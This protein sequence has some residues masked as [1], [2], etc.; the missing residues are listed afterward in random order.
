V[1]SKQ[2]AKPVETVGDRLTREQIENL[3]I[4]PDGV[5]EY[6]PPKYPGFVPK[7][8]IFRYEVPLDPAEGAEPFTFDAVGN[9]TIAECDELQTMLRDGASYEAFWDRLAWRITAWNALAYDLASG[10][11]QPVP[12]PVEG[13]HDSFR[14]IEPALTA[15]MA[16]TIVNKVLG[17]GDQTRPKASGPTPAPAS[18]GD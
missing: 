13:G 1:S 8:R 12:P 3:S 15:L 4:A 9:L 11:Y 10:D 14:V 18:G 7:G 16:A 17:R 5:I 6:T 2:K